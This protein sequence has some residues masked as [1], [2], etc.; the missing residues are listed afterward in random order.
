MS[1]D[2]E[3][4]LD[5]EGGSA[6]VVDMHDAARREKALLPEGH[7]SVGIAVLVVSAILLIMGGGY[8]GS[9]VNGFSSSPFYRNYQPAPRPDLAGVGAGE[10]VA[11]I[12]HWMKEGKKNFGA[13]AAC[14]MPD[15]KGQ[16][17]V[18]PPL[19]GSEWVSGGTT[20]LGAILIRGI[21]GPLT[22]MGQTYASGQVMQSWSSL[23]DEQIAQVLTYVRREFGSLPEGEDGVVTTEMIAAARKEYGGGGSW[24]EAGL[25]AIPA[26][27]NLPGAKVDLQTGKPLGD[28]K[29]EGDGGGDKK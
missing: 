20:R 28:E 25:L 11:W 27:S 16:P 23:S 4:N 29:P 5:Y 24:N 3:K 9:Y 2:T 15:G 6:S 26:E 14:H 19:K 21:S 17:G 10:P 22:V 12:D 18:F 7:E 1:S 8:L 13:C